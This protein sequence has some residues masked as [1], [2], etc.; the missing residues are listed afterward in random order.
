MPRVVNRRRDR[1]QVEVELAYLLLERPEITPSEASELVRQ[2]A[3]NG[4][5]DFAKPRWISTQAK[6]KDPTSN[7]QT[8]VSCLRLT[9]KDDHVLALQ[10]VHRRLV[11]SLLKNPEQVD[12]IPPAKKIELIGAIT[13]TQA[14]LSDEG[15]ASKA[16]AFSFQK[17]MIGMLEAPTKLLR[18][19]ALKELEALA[20]YSDDIIDATFEPVAAPEEDGSVA[21]EEDSGDLESVALHEVAPGVRDISASGEVAQG[22]SERS[23]SPDPGPD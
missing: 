7:V 6:W 13:K 20:G 12:K 16:L 19:Q 14:D 18:K 23:T 21:G 11:A 9:T 10:R 4:E 15:V 5:Y 2:R 8:Y 17:L 22:C 3:T 1:M